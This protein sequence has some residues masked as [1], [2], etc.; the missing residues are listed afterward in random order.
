MDKDDY[1]EL[2]EMAVMGSIAK[3]FLAADIEPTESERAMLRLR[4][5]ATLRDIA[6]MTSRTGQDFRLVLADVQE[7]RND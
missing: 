7:L 2:F 5:P 4:Q 6:Y 3:L 1:A